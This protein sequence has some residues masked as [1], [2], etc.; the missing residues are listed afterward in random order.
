MELAGGVF[1]VGIW[2]MMALVG[3]AS[4]VFWIYT[5]VEVV[6]IPEPVWQHTRD[7]QLVW[8]LLIAL[9]GW[10]GA[11]VY[12]IVARGKLRRAKAWFDQHGYPPPVA[13]GGYPPQPPQ[14]PQPP[15]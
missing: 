2:L 5:L 13:Y 9:L 8:V 1:F 10:I 4:V 6:R 11:L 7:N 12:W 15:S 3:I 14:P